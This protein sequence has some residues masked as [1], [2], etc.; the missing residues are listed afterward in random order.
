M[1]LP[2]NRAN[3]HGDTPM[4]DEDPQGAKRPPVSVS[5]IT[6][7]SEGLARLARDLDRLVGPFTA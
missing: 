4:N 1:S 6:T 2:P 7:S 5:E 3:A